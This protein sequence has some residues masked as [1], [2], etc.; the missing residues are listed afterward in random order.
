VQEEVRQMGGKRPQQGKGLLSTQDD[1]LGL[2][3][4]A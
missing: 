1:G 3:E 2:L 4:K